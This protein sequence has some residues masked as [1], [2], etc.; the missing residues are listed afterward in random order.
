MFKLSVA[1]MLFV[2]SASVFADDVQQNEGEQ[3]TRAS[4]WSPDLEFGATFATDGVF[5]GQSGTNGNP[6]MEA[7]TFG[8]SGPFYV[9]AIWMNKDLGEDNPIRAETDFLVGVTPQLGPFRFDF[10]ALRAHLMPDDSTD[11]WEYKAGVETD[12]PFGITGAFNYYYSPNYVN[13]DIKENVY[14]FTWKKPIN[15]KWTLS[16]SVGRSEFSQNMFAVNSY[17]WL[18]AGISYNITPS[19]KTELKYYTT[20]LNESECSPSNACKSRVVLSFAWDTTLST[21]LKNNQ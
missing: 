15:E 13:F 21:F 11:Y 20:N 2:L 9:G 17:N 4:F 8:L 14:E 5:R 7:H 12:L 19:L 10:N 3:H 6:G 1:V 16:G 18:D